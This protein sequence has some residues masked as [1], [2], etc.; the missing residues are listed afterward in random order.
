MIKQFQHKILSPIKKP[1]IE[2]EGKQ[3]MLLTWKPKPILLTVV[4]CC[5]L[6]GKSNHAKA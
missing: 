6:D 2:K 4:F 1:P 3:R 5:T